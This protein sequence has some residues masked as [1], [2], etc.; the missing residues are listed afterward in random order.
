[1]FPEIDKKQTAELLEKHRRLWSSGGLDERLVTFAFSAAGNFDMREVWTDPQTAMAF[2]LARLARVL[3]TGDDSIPMVR[4]EFGTTLPSIAFGA[5]VR[6]SEDAWPVVNTHPISSLESLRKVRRPDPQTSGEFPKAYEFIRYFREHLPDGVRLCQCDM[7]GPWNTAHLIAGDKIFYDVYDEPTLVAELLDAV[8]DLM[9][10]AIPPMKQAIGE[11]EDSFFLG[12]MVV[13]GSSRVCNCS[14]DM[15]S[16]DFYQSVILERDVRVFEALGGGMMHICGN[17]PHCIKHFNKIENLSCLEVNFNY[18]D[19]FMVS[20]I[21]RE[22]I[23]L[24]CT[25]P[26]DPPLQTPL[27]EKTLNRFAKGE[28][29]DKKNI[30]FHFDDP[31]NEDKCKWLLD[32][33]KG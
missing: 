6:I 26:V 12:G 20:D 19:L 18:L 7:Q 28:F 21:L 13:S 17:N 1:M 23:V 30:L 33:M 5:E 9:V 32:I 27:G 16:P 3:E 2:S 22:D 25:G 4:V 11:P 8:A 14:T 31:A 29:P 10:A 24:Q 15:I